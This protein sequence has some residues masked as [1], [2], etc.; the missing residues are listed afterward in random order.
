VETKA[1]DRITA[2]GLSDPLGSALWR[3]KYLH[4]RAAYKRAL[5]LLASKAQDRLKT[6][7]TNYVIA[8]SVGVLREWSFDACEVCRGVGSMPALHGLTEKCRPCDGTGMKRYTDFERE[9]NCKLPHGTWPKGH[10][11]IFDEIMICLTGA[12]SATGGKVSALLKNH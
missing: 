9:T 5:Y 7:D 2:L 1:I 11:R 6:K 3:F 10:N 8:M 12:A 4:D